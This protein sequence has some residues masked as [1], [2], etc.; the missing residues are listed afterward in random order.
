MKIVA[1]LTPEEAKALNARLGAQL[2]TQCGGWWCVDVYRAKRPLP[3]S[4]LRVWPY[5]PLLPKSV[6]GENT[7]PRCRRVLLQRT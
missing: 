6:K 5:Q 7:G 3:G 2:A 4:G 1:N